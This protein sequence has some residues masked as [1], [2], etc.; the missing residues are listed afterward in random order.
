MGT[1]AAATPGRVE[2][3]FGGEANALAR[4]AGGFVHRPCCGHPAM[5]AR[6]ELLQFVIKIN[7]FRTKVRKFKGLERCLNFNQM[8][9]MPGILTIRVRS[10]QLFNRVIHRFRGYPESTCAINHLTT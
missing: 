7:H 4:P 8:S 3:G 2:L 6:C 1:T 9:Q 10:T 5:R